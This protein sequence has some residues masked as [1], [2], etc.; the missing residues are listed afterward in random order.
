MIRGLKGSW[1]SEFLIWMCRAGIPDK[2]GALFPLHEPGTT[3]A[4]R[5]WT[6]VVRHGTVTRIRV[7]VLWLLRVAVLAPAHLTSAALAL[8]ALEQVELVVMRAQEEGWRG[9]ARRRPG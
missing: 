4:A 3:L 5:S 9:W 7:P 6:L 2:E 1:A 8:C